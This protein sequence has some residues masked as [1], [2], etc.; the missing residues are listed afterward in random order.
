MPGAVNA[1]AALLATL[2]FARRWTARVDFTDRRT[3]EVDLA[4][5]SALRDARE[6]EDAGFRL[7][8]P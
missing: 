4:R 3:A 6:A 8:L 7:Q 1:D 5:T 2:A